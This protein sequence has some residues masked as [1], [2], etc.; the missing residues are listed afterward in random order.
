MRKKTIFVASILATGLLIIM[1]VKRFVSQDKPPRSKGLWD[2]SHWN[3]SCWLPPSGYKAWGAGVVTTLLPKVERNCTKLF[4]GDE[5]EVKR[6]N[7]SLE[8]WESSV[9]DEDLLH[10]TRDCVWLQ[11]YFTEN[12]YITK[13]EKSFPIA[14]N[15]L[16]HNNG[17][18]YAIS[19][20]HTMPTA[21]IRI[22]NLVRS[23]F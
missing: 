15:F 6:V 10:K 23:S 2:Y 12:L 7:K 20:G 19:T 17:D 11:E 1:S 16:I 4:A 5:L 3:S 14:Y 22:K 9:S 13:L 8:N 18:F 21:F